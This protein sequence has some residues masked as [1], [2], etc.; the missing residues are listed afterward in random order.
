[1]C[2]Y[3]SL[4]D[5][6][7]STK[8]YVKKQID[9]PCNSQSFILSKRWKRFWLCFKGQ[10]S[11]PG[12]TLAPPGPGSLWWS[13]RPD[14]GW[15]VPRR[16]PAGWSLSPRYRERALTLPPWDEH[17]CLQFVRVSPATPRR[18]WRYCLIFNGWGS[19]WHANQT[20]LTDLSIHWAAR[21]AVVR[22]SLTWVCQLEASSLLNQRSILCDWSL[23][24]STSFIRLSWRTL[25][26]ETT[27][28]SQY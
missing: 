16:S 24:A 2:P 4:Y 9:I 18:L 12:A 20:L 10:I 8:L 23:H 15:S 19:V 25:D 3:H 5:Q 28:V 1:M 21:Q 22:I 6:H 27:D 7:I 13:C 14:Q 11:L 26:L 17:T